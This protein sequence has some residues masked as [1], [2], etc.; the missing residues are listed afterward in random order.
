MRSRH[1][2]ASE[3]SLKLNYMLYCKNTAIL[4]S[5]FILPKYGS[6]HAMLK[7]SF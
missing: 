5:K 4:N 1:W 6:T 3:I 2:R 7:T